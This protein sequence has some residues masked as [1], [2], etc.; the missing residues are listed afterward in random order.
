MWS[1]QKKSKGAERWKLQNSWSWRVDESYEGILSYLTGFGSIGR[2]A[3][4]CSGITTQSITFGII[5]S[6]QR[7]WTKTTMYT[8]LDCVFM[9]YR[10][11][12]RNHHQNQ[13][14]THD[15]ELENVCT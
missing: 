8:D 15:C 4:A 3:T 1:D 14:V 12:N 6:V 11:G 5:Y 9:I 2:S 7:S 13:D 10:N